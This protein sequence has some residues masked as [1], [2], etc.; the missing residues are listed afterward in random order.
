[1]SNFLPKWLNIWT[2]PAWCVFEILLRNTANPLRLPSLASLAE[3]KPLFPSYS[4]ESPFLTASCLQPVYEYCNRNSM[5]VHWLRTSFNSHFLPSLLSF[6]YP[7]ICN[8]SLRAFLVKISHTPTSLQNNVSLATGPQSCRVTS[9][10]RE[11]RLCLI[12][13]EIMR[14]EKGFVLPLRTPTAA[15]RAA[16]IF[17]CCPCWRADRGA[18]TGSDVSQTA[19]S[20]I[21]PNIDLYCFNEDERSLMI[22]FALVVVLVLSHSG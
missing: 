11:S 19:G 7:S 4:R 12:T 3:E 8:D 15:D 16:G 13:T 22:L 14:V 6:W 5:Y 20:F 18:H 9:C 17:S 2:I 10:T 21:F 1:M